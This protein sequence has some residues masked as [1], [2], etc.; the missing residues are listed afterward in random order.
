MKAPSPLQRQLRRKQLQRADRR[1]SPPLRHTETAHARIAMCVIETL[2]RVGATL[3]V[4][5]A[6]R[7]VW[8]WKLEMGADRGP[9]LRHTG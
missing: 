5:M 6:M 7:V 3:R 1:Q 4:L 8:T 2:L 9:L